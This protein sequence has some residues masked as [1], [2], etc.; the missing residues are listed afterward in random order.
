MPYLQTVLLMQYY[1]FFTIKLVIWPYLTVIPGKLQLWINHSTNSLYGW[2]SDFLTND[3]GI[4][5]EDI[6]CLKIWA[7][8]MG[9][10]LYSSKFY[11][12]HY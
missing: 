6:A 9:F 10:Y 5:V 4:Q 3:S 12:T 11:P 8:I 2:F 1:I 7:K